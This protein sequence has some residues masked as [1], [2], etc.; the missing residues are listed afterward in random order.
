LRPEAT[1]YGLIYMTKIAVEKK[2][3]RT[4][5]GM[6]CAISGSGN[7]AQFAAEKLLEL[8]AKVITFSDSNGVLVFEDGLTAAELKLVVDCKNVQRD[9]LKSL[10]GKVCGR[11]I[12]GGSPW[13]VD[14]KYDLALPC[15]TQNEI[16]GDAARRLVKNGVVGVLEVRNV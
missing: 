15:A 9:R 6:R 2:F 16:D 7:V 12:E 1:G 11:Y 4:L 13:S 3:G 8:G 14:V 5:E 10:E